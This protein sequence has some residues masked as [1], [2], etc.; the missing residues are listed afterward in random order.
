MAMVKAKIRVG[1]SPDADDAFM[2]YAIQ[3]RKIDTGG[4]EISH[5]VEDIQ[6]LNE[7]AFRGD[8][9][10]SAVSAYCFFQL[11]KKYTLMKCGASIGDNYGPVV[12]SRGLNYPKELKDRRVAVPGKNTTA[13][14]LLRLYEESIEPVFAPFDKVIEVMDSGNADAA[15]VIHEGQVTYGDQKLTKVIDLGEWFYEMTELPLPLGVDVVRSDLEPDVMRKIQK[16]FRE[17]IV[18]ALD[19]RDEALEYAMRFGRNTP[20]ETI[21]RFVSMY[22]NDYTVDMGKRGRDGLMHLYESAKASGMIQN[23]NSINFIPK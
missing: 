18:Y 2:F 8:L 20:R 6:S 21:D 7:R 10:V 14:L 16:V 19:H 12:V 17:S 11:T 9:E 1:H 4:L 3:H 22:V 13:Y 23:G 5:V 15:L